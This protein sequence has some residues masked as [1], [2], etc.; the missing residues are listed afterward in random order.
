MRLPLLLPRAGSADDFEEFD[1]RQEY[2][3]ALDVPGIARFHEAAGKVA[4]WL[5]AFEENA[6]ASQRLR[7][8]LRADRA[9]RRELLEHRGSRAAV[10]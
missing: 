7:R 4:A 8:A 2:V 1:P 10:S 9:L 5:L 6:Y 3:P